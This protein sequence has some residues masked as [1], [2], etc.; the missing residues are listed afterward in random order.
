[1]ED[2]ERIQETIDNMSKWQVECRL[3]QTRSTLFHGPV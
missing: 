3:C 1:M 2:S